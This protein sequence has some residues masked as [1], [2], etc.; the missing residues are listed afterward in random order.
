MFSSISNAIATMLQIAASILWGAVNGI[1]GSNVGIA[2]LAVLAM[3]AL[4][5]L[6]RFGAAMRRATKDGPK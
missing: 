1:A 6:F 4:F 2:V 5:L 3:I